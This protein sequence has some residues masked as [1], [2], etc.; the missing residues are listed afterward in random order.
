V[1]GPG[2]VRKTLIRGSYIGKVQKPGKV[3]ERAERVQLSFFEAEVHPVVEALKGLDVEAMTP[4]E[5]LTGLGELRKLV[6]GQSE[7]RC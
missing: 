2:G 6:K 1:G 5:A 3:S 4:L 7:D